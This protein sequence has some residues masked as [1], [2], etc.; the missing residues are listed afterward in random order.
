[1]ESVFD[2]MREL[3][4]LWLTCC[5][6]LGGMAA[7]FAGVAAWR[8]RERLPLLMGE[9]PA[10]GEDPA[11]LMDRTSLWARSKCEG[12]GRGLG[13]LDLLPVLGWL[14]RRGRCPTC[15]HHVSARY[16]LTELASAILFTALGWVHGPSWQTLVIMLMAAILLA[17]A[18]MDWENYCITDEL[19]VPCI[20]VGLYLPAFEPSANLRLWG[21][22]AAGGFMLMGMVIGKIWNKD[23]PVAWGDVMLMAAGGAF[24]GLDCFPTLTIL[25][26]VIMAAYAIPMRVWG[27][28]RPTT[29]MHEAVLDGT[30][31]RS[32]PMGPAIAAAIVV[33]SFSP[34]LWATSLSSLLLP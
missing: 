21:A 13:F 27:L 5:A 7:S 30:D 11:A 16:P 26:V 1:M 32:V 12:C 31:P 25:S 2:G 8:M 23:A 10:N 18:W 17:A 24:L 3:P 4:M 6:L 15:G 19:L 33:I 28:G 29:K 34:G 20:L 14:A 22:A 9:L